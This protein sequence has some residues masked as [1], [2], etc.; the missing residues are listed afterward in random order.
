MIVTNAHEGH[1]MNI[2]P[3]RL[4]SW[5]VAIASALLISG[6]MTTGGDYGN[7]GGYPSGG[8]YP[9]GGQYPQQPYPSQS[10]SQLVGT[11]DSV[12]PNGR[13]LLIAD[14]GTSGGYGSGS[15]IEVMFDQ[16]TQLYYQG[17]S[18]QVAGLERGD[19]IRIEA[20]QSG[21]SWLAHS[22]EV[23]QNVRDTQGGQG[24]QYG[25]PQYGNP[26]GGAVSYVDTRARVIAFTSGGY[27]GATTQVRYDERTAVEYRGQ[28][29]RPENLERGDVV[30]IQ[31]RQ[32]NNE[33]LAERIVV[34]TSARGR[35]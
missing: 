11:V 25:N 14:S 17:Q 13:L 8:Q 26:L 3:G 20:T 18:Y 28:I 29:L 22:I 12:D 31:A 16:R 35:Y 10:G 27:S 5:C 9:A 6:C 2:I 19:R 32:W 21:G 7:T 23:L 34:E 33:W 4:A 1:D 30:R 15:R 24:G